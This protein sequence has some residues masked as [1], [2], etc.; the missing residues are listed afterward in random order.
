MAAIIALLSSIDVL[1]FW[2]DP[3]GIFRSIRNEEAGQNTG[4][5]EGSSA[6]PGSTVMT[7]LG[8]PVRV[9][10]NV[11]GRAQTSKLS[12]LFL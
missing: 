7:G 11:R 2:Q 12:V 9:I 6:L 1:T 3:K 5:T 4:R 8:R 10:A